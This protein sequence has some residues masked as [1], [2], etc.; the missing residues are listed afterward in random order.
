MKKVKSVFRYS[1][2][3]EIARGYEIQ[4]LSKKN[5]CPQCAVYEIGQLGQ[6]RSATLTGR[7]SDKSLPIQ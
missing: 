4:E 3:I 2:D 7:W 6:A 1:K 5:A